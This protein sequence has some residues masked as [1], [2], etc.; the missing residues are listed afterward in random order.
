[1]VVAKT[2][3][4]RVLADGEIRPGTELFLPEFDAYLDQSTLAEAAATARLREHLRGG[5][6]HS[7]MVHQ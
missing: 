7:G 6:G 1:M 3:D 2:V 4:I 5:P